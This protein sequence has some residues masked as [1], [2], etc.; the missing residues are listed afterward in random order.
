MTPPDSSISM[1]ADGSPLV[2]FV[3]VHMDNGL[4]VMNSPL[5]YLWFLQSLSRHLYVV[6]LGI[7][8]KFLSIVIICDCA[9]CCL[10]L[11]S[12]VY[13]TELLTDWNMASC[14]PA[15]TPL[16]LTPLPLASAN[17]L[18]DVS[19]IDLKPKYQRLVSCLLYLAVSTRPNIV[20]TSMWL[21]QFSAN[22][23]RSHFLATKHVLRYL[24]GTCSLALSYGVPH[25]S[26]PST[27]CGFMHNLG[28]SYADW[29][30]DAMHRCSLWVLFL[31]SKLPCVIV[32]SEAAQN[33]P[34]F[35]QS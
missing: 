35:Y 11:S 17:S 29:A 4:G 8:S 3:P 10:W 30:S 18:P 31:L 33:C 9:A 1:P 13:M 34:L 5:L 20:F 15:S 14:C 25:P 26:T 28:C 2:L 24:A 7:C 21:G 32:H 27:L 22:P 19:D 23:S 12:Q 6:D 16:T